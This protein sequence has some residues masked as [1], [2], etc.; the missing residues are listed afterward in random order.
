MGKRKRTNSIPLRARKRSTRSTVYKRSKKQARRLTRYSRNPI[1]RGPMVFKNGNMVP[2]CRAQMMWSDHFTVSDAAGTTDEGRYEVNLNTLVNIHGQVDS[3]VGGHDVKDKPAGYNFISP[4][5]SYYRIYAAKLEL[6]VINNRTP[7]PGGGATEN[8][9]AHAYVGLHMA[10]PGVSGNYATSWQQLILDQAIPAGRRRILGPGQSSKLTLY[11]SEK[12][13][14]PQQ[15]DENISTIGASPTAVQVVKMLFGTCDAANDMNMNCV[16][17][18]TQYVQ[19][20][21]G[22]TKIIETE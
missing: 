3:S 20:S 13:L 21:V 11:W 9:G 16:G 4:E 22:D 2:V 14:N 18:V 12:S 1:Y 5:Y 8:A 6:W 7:S 10:Q 19:F 17:R 15:I